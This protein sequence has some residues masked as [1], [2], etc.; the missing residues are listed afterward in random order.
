MK[1]VVFLGF[2][3][4]L[5]LAGCD[6]E[7]YSPNPIRE[8]VQKNKEDEVTETITELVFVRET[9]T[10]LFAVDTDGVVHEISKG[11]ARDVKVG[12]IAKN[13]VVITKDSKVISIDIN[14]TEELVREPIKLQG[15]PSMIE[16]LSANAILNSYMRSSDYSKAIK[17]YLIKSL[18]VLEG[19]GTSKIKML[20]TF[21]V[22]PMPFALY[23]GKPDESGMVT[24]L[25]YVYTAYGF[26]NDWMFDGF[27][28]DNGSGFIN[29]TTLYEP[30]D[31]QKV[32][33]ETD[34]YTYYQQKDFDNVEKINDVNN[35]SEFKSP[36]YR[37]DRGSGATTR[38]YSGDRNYDYY[39]F[40]QSGKYLFVETRLY[41]AGNTS[42]N[43][44]IGVL[45]VE[46]KYMSEVIDGPAV[47]GT[48][49]EDKVYV[50]AD[51]ELKVL[52]VN[53][54]AVETIGELPFEVDYSLGGTVVD[55]V[56]GVDIH[57]TLADNTKKV[58]YVYNIESK[59]FSINN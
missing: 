29:P 33:Y 41:G 59:E 36:I 44:Y 34:K 5:I 55:Y 1:K 51:Q 31:N 18:S 26:N 22:E 10:S 11:D 24:D 21:D 4:I 2:V 9:T 43:S 3:L 48:M 23:W 12:M 38:M 46:R 57:M 13:A 50:F 8:A 39:P 40:Y 27:I 28:D 32:L 14:D 15:E 6:Y 42:K 56:N 49:I 30:G 16:E 47:Y 25:S 53:T 37:I 52:N 20:V 45:D 19:S 54:L 35:P 58:E 17:S 7:I